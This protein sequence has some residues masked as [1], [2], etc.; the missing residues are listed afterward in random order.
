MPMPAINPGSF[1]SFLRTH[2]AVVGFFTDANC[3][4][5]R[6][7]EPVVERLAEKK[8]VRQGVVFV[9]ITVLADQHEITA[10]HFLVLLE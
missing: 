5:C 2:R 8:G 7:V 10:T 4:P 1:S 3:T 9:K 6:A